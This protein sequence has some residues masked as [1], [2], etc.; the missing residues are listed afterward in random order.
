MNV[1][2]R[3]NGEPSAS[4]AG[5]ADHIRAPNPAVT[6]SGVTLRTRE[7]GLRMALGGGRGHVL[8]LV[9]A[10]AAMPAIAGI[11]G[12]GAG[13]LA[14]AGWLRAGLFGVAP[15]DP[16]TFTGSATLLL[17]VT[18]AAA[19]VPARRALRVDPVRALREE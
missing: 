8:R 6:I 10:T 4:L 2:V 15:T 18:I 7:M 5:L 1:V 12:G 9:L 11:V 16:I 17:G 13:A 14:A 19:V 3:T